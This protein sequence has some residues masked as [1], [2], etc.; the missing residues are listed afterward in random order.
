MA[1]PPDTLAITPDAFPIPG[2]PQRLADLV[3]RNGQPLTLAEIVDH[4]AIG[5]RAWGTPAGD[6]LARQIERLAQLIRWTNAESPEDHEARME[7]W[8]EEIRERWFDR[9]YH[10]G[11]EAGRREAVGDRHAGWRE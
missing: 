1:M 11:Y 3:P 7:V 8:D 2:G 5:Y 9:G 10:E 6:L 4:E